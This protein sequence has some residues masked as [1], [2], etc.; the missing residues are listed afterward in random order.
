MMHP[1]RT[2]LFFIMISSAAWA[3]MYGDPSLVKPDTMKQDTIQP[4][5]VEEAPPEV[6]PGPPAV[7]LAKLWI[8]RLM[9]RGVLNTNHIG[10]FAE[11]QLTK[12]SL[13]TGSA[14]PIRAYLKIVYLGPTML[15]GEDVE[16]VQATARILGAVDKRVAFDFLVSADDT[17]ALP[18]RTLMKEDGGALREISLALPQGTPDYDALD[19]PRDIREETVELSHGKY[20]CGHFRGSGDD[21]AR[22]DLYLSPEVNPYGIVV[23]G[24]GDEGLTLIRKGADATP[25]L[26]VPPPPR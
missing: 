12:W 24:Y 1:A 4:I 6:T 26:D 17:Q 14:G 8:R 21:G 22:V 2:T 9:L 15:L 18:L 5:I 11:Y 3:Q 23:M 13:L 19:N 25:L 20:F 16:W 10:A 7:D